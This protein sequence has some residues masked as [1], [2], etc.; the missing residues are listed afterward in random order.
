MSLW[1]DFFGSEIRYVQTPTFGHVRIAEAGRGNPE[2]LI[3]LHGIG[4][5]IEA[6]AKNVMALSDQYHVVAM[7]FVGHGLS[8]KPTTVDYTPQ[9]YARQVAEVMDTLGIRRAHMSGESLGGWV[10]GFF[11]T[12]YPDRIDRHVMNTAAGIPVVSEKGRQDQRNLEELSKKATG[13]TPTYESVLARMQ[14]LLHKNNWGLLNEELVNTRLALYLQPELREVAPLIYKLIHSH[15]DYLIPLE[16]V[17]CETLYLWTR[18]NPVHDLETA[19]ASVARTPNAQLYV[20]EADSCHWPQYEAP[21]EFNLVMRQF[22][23][24]GR[25]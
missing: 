5:H 24:T 13:K 19:K 18:D 14:W 7:D 11:A 4:G 23:S 25:I 9:T 10:S 17:K 15:D 12:M 16:R 22:L 6:Y 8:N 21:D 20:M 1:L 2:A 3:L